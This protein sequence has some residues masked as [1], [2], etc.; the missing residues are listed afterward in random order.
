MSDN[1]VRYRSLGQRSHERTTSILRIVP[2]HTPEHAQA[3]GLSDAIQR[4]MV[5]R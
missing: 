4:Y 3:I 5:I 2:Y 1:A